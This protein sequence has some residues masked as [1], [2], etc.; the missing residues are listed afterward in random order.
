MEFLE[1]ILEY[2]Y[3]LKYYFRKIVLYNFDRSP[4]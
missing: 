2:M 4:G 3:V 1:Y